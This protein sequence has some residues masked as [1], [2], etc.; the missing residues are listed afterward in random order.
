MGIGGQDRETVGRR[1]E[2]AP[3]DDEIAVAIAV[4]RRAEV[5]PPADMARSNNAWR[6]IKIGVGVM[7][8]EVRQ[9]RP[10][11]NQVRRRAKHINEDLRGIRSRHRR[12]RI[13]T[14][15]KTGFEQAPDA[16]EIEQLLH[17]FRVIVNRI[18]HF[19]LAWPEANAA[20]HIEIDIRR[21]DDFI[22]GDP[23]RAGKHGLGQFFRRRPAISHI[24]F[25]PEVAVRPTW[26]VAR[27]E[28]HAAEGAVAA[29]QIRGRGRRQYAAPPDQDFAKPIGDRDLQHD[30]D[31]LAIEEA[32]VAANDQ[33]R[34]LK[35][36]ETIHDRLNE[37]LD[38]ARLL[39]SHGLFAQARG[40]GPLIIEGGGWNTI[41]HEFF[42]I[43]FMGQGRHRI[44][45][46]PAPA[47]TRPRK[48]FA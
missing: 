6:I 24:V 31:R 26:I 8:A 42:P 11:Q 37:I 17:Q 7:A 22:L 3:A 9:R 4:R 32:A 27:A 10:I 41:D 35:T 14:K 2:P 45:R 25:D 16:V 38:I 47:A 46:Q 34:A 44:G 13:E 18:D 40:S 1:D 33:R 48:S 15:P 5:G 12:H 23:F 19:D 29:D 30:L 39:E 20:Q 36:F 43:Q 21:R 28:D